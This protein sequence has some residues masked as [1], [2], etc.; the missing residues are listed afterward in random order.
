MSAR[1]LGPKGSG[2]RGPTSI[3]EGNECQQGRWALKGVDRG[4]PHR[5]E[6]GTSVGKDAGPERGGL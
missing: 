4:V 6:K 1:T 3:G 2:L 5:L